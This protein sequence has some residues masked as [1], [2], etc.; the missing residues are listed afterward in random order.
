MERLRTLL[1]KRPMVTVVVCVLVVGS[2]IYFFGGFGRGPKGKYQSG[3]VFFTA[4]DGATYSPADNWQMPPHVDPSGKEW[5][6]ARV[7]Q[8]NGKTSVGYLEKYTPR[9]YARLMQA[10]N[11][12][13]LNGLM[14]EMPG[15][16]LVKRPLTG[17]WVFI[18][19]EE[20]AAVRNIRCGDKPAK[21]IL[22]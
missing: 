9:A 11:H 1:H 14:N 17:N 18:N 12:G 7:F 2:L 22:P 20:G 21:E 13:Q 19:S 6:R 3:D 4:D 10:E 16:L 8:C 5:V 15:E